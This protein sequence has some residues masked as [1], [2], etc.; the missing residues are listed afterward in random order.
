MA[1]KSF[2]QQ[3][4]IG[5]SSLIFGVALSVFMIAVATGVPGSMGAWLL[6]IATFLL[7]LRF[8]WRYNEL[9]VQKLQSKT[10]FHFLFD[11]IIAFFGILAVIFVNNIHLWALVGVIT[12]AA[13]IIRCS[14]SW[15]EAKSSRNN[16]A[17]RA[18]KRTKISSAAMIVIFAI[19]YWIAAYI[20]QLTLSAAIL[21]L[22]V[23]FVAWS[24]R[25]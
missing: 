9:F 17:M 23:I 14:L 5:V 22:V 3:L 10:Y 11:F 19:I 8:W 16:E 2:F 13:S 1:D 24:S 20:E 21:V 7:M 12:M 25:K 18:L 15:K 4:G 6:F